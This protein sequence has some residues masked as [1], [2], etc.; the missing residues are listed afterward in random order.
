VSANDIILIKNLKKE[1]RWVR[2]NC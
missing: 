2:T 1:R